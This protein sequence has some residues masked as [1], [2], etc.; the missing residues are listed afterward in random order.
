MN[1]VKRRFCQLLLKTPF[2]KKHRNRN[3][4]LEK[5]GVTFVKEEPYSPPIID[6]SIKIKG[7]LG[8]L[9]CIMHAQYIMVPCWLHTTKSK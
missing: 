4:L 8:M 1:E 6:S 5:L 9:Y 2:A 3:C 7:D